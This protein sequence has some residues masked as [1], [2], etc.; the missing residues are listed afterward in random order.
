[1]TSRRRPYCRSDN[2]TE[3][4]TKQTHFSNEVVVAVLYRWV[5]ALVCLLKRR[6]AVIEAPKSRITDRHRCA[7]A[8]MKLVK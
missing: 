6:Q 7:G 1:M 3:E 2:R 8:S 5:A 4:L